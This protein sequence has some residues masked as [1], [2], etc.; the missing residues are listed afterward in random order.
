MPGAGKKVELSEAVIGCRL[1][2][3][4]Y[5]RDST[6]IFIRKDAVITNFVYWRLLEEGVREVY[7]YEEAEKAR[8]IKQEQGLEAAQ[9]E[10]AARAVKLNHLFNEVIN[11]Q[12]LDIAET[13]KICAEIIQS[14][15]DKYNIFLLLDSLR[16]VDDYLYSHSVNVA[17]LAGL[18]GKW[19]EFS[20]KEIELLTMCGLLHDIGKTM[21]DA[22]ILQKT[23]KLTNRE[24]SEIKTHTVKGYQL[25][26]RQDVPREVKEVAYMHHEKIDGTGYPRG[27]KEKDISNYSKII[28]IADIFD[29][30]SHARVYRKKAYSPF[31][32][33]KD[34][35]EGTY[36]KL[37]VKYLAA[38]LQNV[39]YMYTGARCILSDG[40]DGKIVFVNPVTLYTPIVEVDGKMI[41]LQ[42]E[43]E[44]TIDDIIMA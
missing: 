33:L 28:T 35:Q 15:N 4:I 11:N 2:R 32:I 38:F 13:S 43:R 41:D 5:R 24:F 16:M 10:H 3:D 29:A 8:E 22:D 42:F 19:L 34:F 20:E 31:Y 30:M 6:Y 1:A 26:E 36:G 17:T 18:F 14:N 39:A 9:R 7:V 25:L 37:D 27:L 44:L 23:D 12:K 21:V 40:R